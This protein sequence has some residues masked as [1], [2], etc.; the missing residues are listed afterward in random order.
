MLEIIEIH[1]SFDGLPLLKG[2]SFKVEH[3]EVVCLLG[4]SG[5]GKSTLLRMVAGLEEPERGKILWLGRDLANVPTHKRNFSLMFQDYALFPHL[6]VKGNIEYGMR[7]QKW[8]ELRI[9]EKVDNLAKMVGLEDSL[10]RGV[11]DLSGGEQQRVALARALAVEPMLLMLDEP[12][13]ALDRKMKQELLEELRSIL[14]ETKLPS[15]Y[16]THDQEEAF[17]I[18]DRIILL[19]NGVIAQAAEPK[20]IFDHPANRW[21]AEFMGLGNVLEAIKG[22]KGWKTPIGIFP[23]RMIECTEE[24][25]VLLIRPDVE[26]DPT[27]PIRGTVT[28]VIF[29]REG[30]QIELNQTYKFNLPTQVQKGDEISLN[31]KKVSVLSK[32]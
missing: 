23:T 22:D 24:N 4:A 16:V 6:S 32:A 20:E 18:A 2:V 13:G 15:I 31:P 5:S 21:V 8:D 12:L 9:K 30:F 19:N 28:D 7:R 10:N 26:L 1:K 29:D 14:R 25:A 3:G 17:A 11:S 27:G